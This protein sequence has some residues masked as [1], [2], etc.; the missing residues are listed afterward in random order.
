MVVLDST[1]VRVRARGGAI[2]TVSVT[3]GYR[4]I[5]AARVYRLLDAPLVVVSGGATEAESPTSLEAA[6]LRD[7]L[8]K[9]GVPL[10][11]IVLDT[12]SENTRA[13]A[14]NL[15]PILRAHMV[16]RI[17]LVTSLTHIRRAAHAFQAVGID[18][19]PSPAAVTNRWVWTEWWPS[20]EWLQ[21]SEMGLRDA[22]A[23]VSYWSL[24]WLAVRPA[25]AGRGSARLHVAF[26]VSC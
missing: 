14:V 25:A 10:Q 3:S 1:T 22:M 4:A 23:L 5:E 11:R 26:R 13:Q 19:V 15:A 17:V 8:V 21:L 16:S 18:V 7:E 2:D 6:A 24:G 20:R 12:A 9:A